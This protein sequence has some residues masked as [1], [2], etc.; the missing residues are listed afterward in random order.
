[1]K[2]NLFQVLLLTSDLTYTIDLFLILINAKRY[3]AN[4]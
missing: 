3:E 4:G 1:M 2:A